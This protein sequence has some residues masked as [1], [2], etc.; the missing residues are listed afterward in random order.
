MHENATCATLVPR[1]YAH[2]AS[3]WKVRTMAEQDDDDQGPARARPSLIPPAMW[4]RNMA[5]NAAKTLLREVQDRAA[6]GEGDAASSEERAAGFDLRAY[7][8][9][10]MMDLNPLRTLEP[11]DVLSWLQRHG[12]DRWFALMGKW[13]LLSREVVD[14]LLRTN[15]GKSQKRNGAFYDAMRR[16]EGVAQ[17]VVTKVVDFSLDTPE[18]RKQRRRRDDATR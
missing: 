5:M 4:A 15:T 8:I 13:E 17:F 1:A 14:E 7:L 18:A 2:D 6:D 9:A 11:D 10:R 12:Q 3:A 16:W